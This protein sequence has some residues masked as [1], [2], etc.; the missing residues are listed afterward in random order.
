MIRTLMVDAVINGCAIKT[1]VGLTTLVSFPNDGFLDIA[2][3]LP[4]T[5]VPEVT[6]FGDGDDIQ[7][8]RLSMA[9]QLG[10]HGQQLWRQRGSAIGH[11]AAPF[12]VLGQGAKPRRVGFVPM[13]K[14]P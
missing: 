7:E 14:R 5:H 13:V 8:T 6:N 12:A 9:E 4:P 2:A 1:R 10:R 3:L 11:N